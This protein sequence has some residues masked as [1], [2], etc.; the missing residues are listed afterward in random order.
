MAKIITH[1]HFLSSYRSHKGVTLSEDIMWSRLLH[2]SHSWSFDWSVTHARVSHWLFILMVFVFQNVWDGC[3]NV[4]FV[5]WPLIGQLDD[6]SASDWSILVTW[7][8]YWPLIGQQ[9]LQCNNGQPFRLHQQLLSM[10]CI[11][12]LQSKIPPTWLTKQ[13]LWIGNIF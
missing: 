6:S 11:F 7:P 9:Y 4:E 2:V 8:E 12:L 13:S 1:W 10:N 5:S 3:H